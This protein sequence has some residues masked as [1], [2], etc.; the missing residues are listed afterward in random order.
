MQARR[1]P[2]GSKND[3]MSSSIA[4]KSIFAPHPSRSPN[5]LGERL[6]RVGPR[7]KARSLIQMPAGA[8][9]EPY[10]TLGEGDFTESS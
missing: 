3:F 1:W 6:R 4:L 9:S 10:P 2:E 7:A 8:E 5:K